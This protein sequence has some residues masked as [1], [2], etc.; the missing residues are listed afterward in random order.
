MKR[1]RSMQEKNLS[2][3]ERERVKESLY[4]MFVEDDVAV[5]YIEDGQLKSSGIW[6]FVCRLAKVEV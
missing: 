4:R 5:V 3:I 1:N 2:P 6:D